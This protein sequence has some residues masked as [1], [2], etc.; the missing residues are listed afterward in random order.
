MKSN[1]SF[2]GSVQELPLPYLEGRL[3]PVCIESFASSRKVKVELED[4]SYMIL[5]PSEIRTFQIQENCSIEGEDYTEL[6]QILCKRARDKAM[7]L[8]KDRDR[9]EQDIRIRLRQNGFLENVIEDAI[10]YLYHYHY[11]DDERY[12]SQYIFQNRERKSTR[13]IVQELKQ[14]GISEDL[15]ESYLESEEENQE[16]QVARKVY[17][18][19]CKRKPVNDFKSKQKAASY[20][21]SKGFTWETISAIVFTEN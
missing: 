3:F 14:K 15:I 18:K 9:T 6:M 12:V 17:E 2:C 13:Q 21:M 7:F 1:P 20:L 11:L 8:L 16:E 19:Y 4:G 10:L 5:Y